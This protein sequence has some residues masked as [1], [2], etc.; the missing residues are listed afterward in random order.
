[1]SKAKENIQELGPHHRMTV[2]QV[3]EYLLRNPPEDILV[4]GYDE[5]GDLVHYSSKMTRA[6]ALWLLEQS[7]INCLG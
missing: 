2:Q 5:N 7:K 6:E 1:M 4:V 3:L